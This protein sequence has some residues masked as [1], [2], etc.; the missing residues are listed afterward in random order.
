MTVIPNSV[1][2]SYYNELND[3]EKIKRREEI[4]KKYAVLSNKIW[5]LYV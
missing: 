5:L 4:S 3:N 1:D 2:L